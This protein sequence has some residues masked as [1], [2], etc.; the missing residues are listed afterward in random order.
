MVGQATTCIS[1]SDSVTP[2]P[3]ITVLVSAEEATATEGQRGWSQAIETMHK[4]TSALVE[5]KL[6][7]VALERKMAGFL[8]MVGRLFA[9]ADQQMQSQSTL[10]AELPLC[11][12][13]SEIELS[14]E[15]GA[16][17]EVKLVAGGEASGK[18]AIKLKFTRS[19][20]N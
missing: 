4:R 15:I 19:V 10:P 11:I 14:V 1:M 16:K 3:E 2:P 6:D 20:A 12:Q 8:S 13:L 17:G 18:G 7:P 5:V 9:Q